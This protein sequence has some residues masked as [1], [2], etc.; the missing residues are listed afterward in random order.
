MS[1]D[2]AALADV[3]LHPK[4]TAQEIAAWCERH[5]MYVT[6]DYTT[7]PDGILQPL[8]TARREVDPNR[9]PCFFLRQA[10]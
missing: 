9:L 7:G 2:L 6:I 1:A 3:T 5:K 8:I 10:E 4:M